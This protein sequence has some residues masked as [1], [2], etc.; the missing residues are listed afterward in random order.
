MSIGNVTL[1]IKNK[2]Y[3]LSLFASLIEDTFT[4]PKERQLMQSILR[5]STSPVKSTFS[6][7]LAKLLYGDNSLSCPAAIYN[8]ETRLAWQ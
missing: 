6:V 1:E 8:C 3:P 7:L 5:I 2:I 4:P